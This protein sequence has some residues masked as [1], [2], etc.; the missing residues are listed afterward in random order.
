MSKEYM[1]TNDEINHV[2]SLLN[3][4]YD[5]NAILLVHT[6]ALFA[7]RLIHM[8]YLP[9]H[10]FENIFEFTSKEIA[11]AC[12]IMLLDKYGMLFSTLLKD[13]GI[14]SYKDINKILTAMDNI[15]SSKEITGAIL[16]SWFDDKLIEKDPILDEDCFE[17]IEL[18]RVILIAAA[19]TKNVIATKKEI[20]KE[21]YK[22]GWLNSLKDFIFRIF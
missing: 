21:I 19:D 12:R 5:V 6:A 15:E 20:P 8:N 10:L 1:I 16:K 14:T 2:F 17:E 9:K 18:A 7:P 11:I 22:K 4:E 3:G 13:W